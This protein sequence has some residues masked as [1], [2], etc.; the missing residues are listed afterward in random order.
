MITTK[1]AYITASAAMLGMIATVWAAVVDPRYTRP[2]DLEPVMEQVND[3]KRM[4][5][6]MATSASREIKGLKVGLLEM[7]IDMINTR[8]IQLEAI[9]RQRK[10]R[11]D[12]IYQK[13]DLEAKLKRI[14]RELKRVEQTHLFIHKYEKYVYGGIIELRKQPKEVKNA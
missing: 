12:E 11:A 2:K 8:L 1:I 14:N 3:N 7:R 9:K 6:D 13:K 5:A 4:I 10:L